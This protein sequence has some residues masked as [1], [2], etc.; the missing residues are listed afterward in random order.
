M[1]ANHTSILKLAGWAIGIGLLI[2]LCTA[3]VL[4]DKKALF[5]HEET[6]SEGDTPDSAK[7]L[8]GDR[9]TIVVEPQV[10]SALGIKTAA[11]EGPD[12]SPLRRMFGAGPPPRTLQLNGSLGYNTDRFIGIN[13]IFSGQVK[14]IGTTNA[15]K[16]DESGVLSTR[17]RPI[18]FGDR[19]QEGDLLAVL[20]SKDLG[21]M[22]SQLVGAASQL[23]LDQER[24]GALESL[25]LRGALPEQTVRDAR[26]KVESDI[27]A[28]QVAR[29]TLSS[30]QV[31]EDVINAIE[32]EAE[33]LLERYKQRQLI[34]GVTQLRKDREIL[35]GLEQKAGAEGERSEARKKVA[36]DEQVVR[37][38]W[39]VLHGPGGKEETLDAIEKE[40]NLVAV[41]LKKRL[42]EENP[43]EHWARVEIRAPFSGTILERNIA[44]GKIINDTTFDLFKIADL[45]RLRVQ[46]NVYEDDLHELQNPKLVQPIR[47]TV[48]LK[49]D[50]KGDS[51]EGWIDKIGDVV[52]PNDHTLR[53]NGFVNN[54]A[55]LFRVGQFITATVPLVTDERQVDVPASAIVTADRDNFV[56][57]QRDPAR[58]EYTLRRVKVLRRHQ[59]WV[60][61]E[62]TA[63]NGT[64]GLSPGDRVVTAGAVELK[65]QLD[66]L[67]NAK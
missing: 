54:P 21:Q 5:K 1:G 25:Y 43:E 66:D 26:Q 8:K 29:K 3:A 10:V 39:R 45:S 58:A 36:A 41:E 49:G 4:V 38:A 6:N 7:L 33:T 55:N 53:V 48:R 16:P 56:F 27:L 46:A 2:G 18:D 31:K 67:Q 9:D 23:R 42:E 61:V 51:I 15:P 32:K 65:S 47:W 34:E 19:V 40:A 14:E 62:Q 13:S 35:S 50:P 37:V 17:P 52:D 64:T 12:T 28:V 63:D 60:S 22:K 20:W 30:W 59:D 24:L 57:I 11:A 44:P